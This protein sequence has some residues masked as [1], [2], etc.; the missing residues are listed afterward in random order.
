MRWEKDLKIGL[1][2]K[3]ALAQPQK[4]HLRAVSSRWI[5]TYIQYIDHL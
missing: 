5:D 4:G 3:E 2:I 1:E